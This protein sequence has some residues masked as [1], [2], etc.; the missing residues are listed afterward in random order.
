MHS[1][2]THSASLT[3]RIEALI[4][5]L[6]EADASLDLSGVIERCERPLPHECQGFTCNNSLSWQIIHSN[7]RPRPFAK[8]LLASYKVRT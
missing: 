6:S 4:H 5:K 2:V 3:L 8:A 7:P 1:Q